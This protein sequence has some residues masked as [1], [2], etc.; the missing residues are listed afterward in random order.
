MKYQT[1]D[2]ANE[3]SKLR[4][5]CKSRFCNICNFFRTQNQQGWQGLTRLTR[6]T[7]ATWF[8]LIQA[9]IRLLTYLE[10]QILTSLK[11]ISADSRQLHQVE[12]QAWIDWLERMIF[13]LFLFDILWCIDWLERIFDIPRFWVKF[14]W[15]RRWGRVSLW[16]LWHVKFIWYLPLCFALS[17]CST[18]LVGF[19]RTSKNLKTRFFCRPEAAYF[20]EK[21]SLLW[22]SIYWLILGTGF[23]EW[24]EKIVSMWRRNLS[25]QFDL[26]LYCK[27]FW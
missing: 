3:G 10:T 8:L 23:I 16:L 7:L 12:R 21:S 17:S 1:A 5:G 6:L 13:L 14:D 2:D 20:C 27:M 25:G 4:K 22:N 18:D 15:S 9:S 11:I 26:L 24:T 19:L